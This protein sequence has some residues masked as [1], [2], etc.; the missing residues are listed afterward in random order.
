MSAAQERLDDPD[1][2]NEVE[3]RLADLVVE[4]AVVT[5]LVPLGLWHGDHKKT[6]R[7]CLRLASRVHDRQW[8]VYDEL[9]YYTE[10]PEQV[11][12]AKKRIEAHGFVMEPALAPSSDHSTKKLAMISCYRSQLPCLG[13]RVAVAVARPEVFHLLHKGL[14]APE[15][16]A[17]TGTKLPKL[18]EP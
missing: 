18:S 9:P 5:W 16:D 1:I 4:L 10:V 12:A 3:K 7:A 15:A 11:S 14:A 6:A 8:V 13:D 17:P 2:E